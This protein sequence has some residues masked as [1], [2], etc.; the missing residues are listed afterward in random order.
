MLWHH[1]FL[2]VTEYGE[3]TQSLAIVFKV[4]VALFLFVSGYGLTR[5]YR[6][7]DKHNKKTTGLFLLRRY[8]NFF[9]PFWFCF[10]LIVLVG[11]ICGYT[12][13]DAYPVTRNTLKCFILDFWGQMGYN[14]YLQPWWFNKMIIQLYLVFP[15]LYLVIANKYSAIVGLVAIGLL[16][17][18]AHRLPGNIFFVVEGG[19]PAFYLGMCL[20]RYRIAPG[21]QNKTRRFAMLAVVF[22]MIVALSV[23]L[24]R[25]IK[26]PYQAVLLQALMALCIVCAFKAISYKGNLLG[27][28]GKYATIMYLTH[29]LFL[30]IIPQVIFFPK[31]SVL[32]FILFAIICF[33]T[34]YFITWLEKV[35]HYDKLRLALVNR[36]EIS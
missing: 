11:N 36:L 4:C 31:Y 12:F 33:V 1:L 5:Q 30:K 8:T 6:A 7:I 25:V 35:S 2:N 22:L 10:V 26:D 18:I 19:T 14:S 23:L 17:L 29:V 24:L 15:L 32:V 3:I 20:A 34:A 21:F 27:H 16:Q 9:L 13:H 28:V